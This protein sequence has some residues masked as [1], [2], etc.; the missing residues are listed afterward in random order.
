[1]AEKNVVDFLEDEFF[2]EEE[3]AK[4]FKCS[5]SHIQRE[6]YEGRG[7]TYIKHGRRILYPKSMVRAYIEDNRVEHRPRVPA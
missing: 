4:M 7:P 3:L 6:R 5:K 2:T 1:M